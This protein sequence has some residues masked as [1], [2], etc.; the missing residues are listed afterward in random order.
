M[1][2]GLEVYYHWL[3]FKGSLGTAV[4][5]RSTYVVVSKAILAGLFRSGGEALPSPLHVSFRIGVRAVR[6]SA[7]HVGLRIRVF[8]EGEGNIGFMQGYWK[9]R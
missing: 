9:G 2:Y 6:P 5:Y 4:P 1:A 7:K 3:R 8:P